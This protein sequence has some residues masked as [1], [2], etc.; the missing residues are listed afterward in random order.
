MWTIVLSVHSIK[1]II[2]IELRQYGHVMKFEMFEKIWWSRLRSQHWPFSSINRSL[3]AIWL[4]RDKW[5]QISCS[6]IFKI[7]VNITFPIPIP[8]AQ[9]QSSFKD[10][11]RSLRTKIEE[12]YEFYSKYRYR[13]TTSLNYET[14]MYHYYTHLYT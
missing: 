12:Y 4:F 3:F 6:N 11:N 1:I 2:I 8:I 9:C 14:R 5:I 13:S 10:C 7:K